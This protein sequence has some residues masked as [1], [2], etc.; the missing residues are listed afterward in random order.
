MGHVQITTPLGPF[1]AVVDDG[2]VTEARFV[3]GGR[4]RNEDPQVH[5]LLEAYFAGDVG[6]LDKIQVHAQGTTFQHKVWDALR[7]IPVGETWSYGELAEHIGT[8]GASRAVGTANASN[9]V[10]LIV[11]CHRVVRT[12]GSIGGYGFGPDRKRWLL[13]HEGARSPSI[14]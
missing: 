5:E 11:P 12:D 7:E 3:D 10:G 9:P 6:A 1:L 13:E 14:L 2:L 4:A 8:P